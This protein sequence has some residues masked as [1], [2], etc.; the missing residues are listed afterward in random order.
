MRFVYFEFST[1]KVLPS[2]LIFCRTW[3]P[4]PTKIY[5]NPILSRLTK[6]D[7]NWQGMRTVGRI[8]YEDGGKA[9]IDKDSLYKPIVRERRGKFCVFFFVK[10]VFFINFF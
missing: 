3:V 4:V 2:D 6:E 1:D 5:Y 8:R 10:N 9:R 7:T